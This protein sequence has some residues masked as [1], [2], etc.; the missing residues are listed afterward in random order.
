LANY[1]HMGMV[2]VGDVM[3]EKIIEM[4]KRSIGIVN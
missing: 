3:K 2:R 1:S 4:E